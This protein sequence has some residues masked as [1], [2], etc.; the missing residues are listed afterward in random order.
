MDDK[1]A[2]A[3]IDQV[4]IEL[5]QLEKRLRR[6]LASKDDLK[7]FPTKDNPQAF[8]TKSDLEGFA[9]KSDLKNFATKD[10]LKNVATKDELRELRQDIIK[11][12][13]EILGE[14]RKRHEEQMILSADHRRI[15]E[16]EDQVENLQQLHPAGRHPNP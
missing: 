6:D 12:K 5:R 2:K 11:M 16:L 15:L 3:I 4:K 10:D 14:F 1:T 8:A 13:D 7:N 9:T